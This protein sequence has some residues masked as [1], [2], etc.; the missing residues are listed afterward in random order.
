MWASPDEEVPEMWLWG[1]SARARNKLQKTQKIQCLHG[2]GSCVRP[3]KKHAY[4]FPLELTVGAYKNMER[5]Y[6]METNRS[7]GCVSR[8]TP[9]ISGPGYSNYKG[10]LTFSSAI[11]TVHRMAWASLFFQKDASHHLVIENRVVDPVVHT[12]RDGHKSMVC[13]QCHS[14][15]QTGSVYALTFHPCPERIHHHRIL[16]QES[17]SLR[18]ITSSCAQA[19]QFFATSLG[20]L[21]PGTR[22]ICT[23]SPNSRWLSASLLPITSI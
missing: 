2:N 22:V 18:G 3:I 12:S 1:Q 14:S 13:P 23:G 15:Q 20:T 21:F 17:N 8:S 10:H 9:G 19:G 6:R 16:W 5:R 4:F 11:T 7:S